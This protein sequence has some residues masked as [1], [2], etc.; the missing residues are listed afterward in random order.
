MKVGSFHVFVTSLDFDSKEEDKFLYQ[1]NKQKSQLTSH[2]HTSLMPR[3]SPAKYK[4]SSVPNYPTLESKSL[5][6]PFLGRFHEK[7]LSVTYFNCWHFYSFTLSFFI[8]TANQLDIGGFYS[9]G[10]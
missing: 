9:L 5:I 6:G 8:G 2:P 4:T 7:N 3:P 10:D 1:Y